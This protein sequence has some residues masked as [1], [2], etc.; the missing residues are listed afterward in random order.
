MLLLTLTLILDAWHAAWRLVCLYL[1]G[2]CWGLGWGVEFMLSFGQKCLWT[3]CNIVNCT[4]FHH[5]TCANVNTYPIPVCP[6]LCS[7]CTVKYCA[8]RRVYTDGY[9]ICVCLLCVLRK[10]WRIRMLRSDTFIHNE[11]PSRYCFHFYFH[12]WVW[13]SPYRNY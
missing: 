8:G 10:W 6:G 11:S 7:T 2:H 4:I 5:P 12:Y 9:F 13:I 3:R 1:K